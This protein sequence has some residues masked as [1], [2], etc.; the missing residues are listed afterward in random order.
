LFFL[1]FGFE[2]SEKG[3]SEDVAERLH[4]LGVNSDGM[5]PLGEV[6]GRASGSAL[7]RCGCGSGP[8][9]VSERER[10]R[11]SSTQSRQAEWSF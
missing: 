8:A 4:E 5:S 2:V 11:I 1:H 7:R 3:V 9:N 10:R 6:T